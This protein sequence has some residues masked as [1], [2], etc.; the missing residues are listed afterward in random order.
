MDGTQTDKDGKKIPPSIK[1][2]TSICTEVSVDITV[3]FPK[4]RIQEL[5]A[6]VDAN[7]CNALEKTLKLFT[8]VSTTNMHMFNSEIKL[9]KYSNVGEIID[10]FYGVRM[11]T[12]KKRKT[13]QVDAMEKKL[14]RLSNKVRYILETLKGTIDLRRKTADQVTELLSKMKFDMIE[15]DYK[16]LIKMPMDSVTQENVDAITKEQ[17]ALQTELAELRAMSLETIWLN[18]LNV[19]ETQYDIYKTRREAIQSAV[20]VAP[21]KIKIAK[22]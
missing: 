10:D 1:D 4:G 17:T 2:F 13:A 5:E 8:T 9:H 18:E 19:L 15:G 11:E 20:K 7:G 12:Y 6:S 21:K 22:K 16:Y 3:Q 14:V